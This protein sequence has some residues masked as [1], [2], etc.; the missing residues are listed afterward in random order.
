MKSFFEA[1]GQNMLLDMQE[2]AHCTHS[3]A[4]INKV[5]RIYVDYL[6]EEEVV[7][8]LSLIDSPM[9]NHSAFLK[10]LDKEGVETQP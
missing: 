8:Y 1:V 5:I 2:G 9:C 7:Y 3:I 6:T 4:G 10:F